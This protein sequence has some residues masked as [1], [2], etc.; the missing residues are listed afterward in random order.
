MADN[1]QEKIEDKIIDCINSESDGRLVIFKPE[2]LNKVLVVERKGEYKNNKQVIL[3]VFGSEKPGGK[4]LEKENFLS[5]NREIPSTGRNVYLV[6]VSFDIVK[7][8]LEDSFLVIPAFKLSEV[9]REKN[10]SKFLMDKRSFTR[11]LL[12]QT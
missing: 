10:L 5:I 2:N 8:D 7:Q 9:K 1:I 3:N 6:F 12:E 11:L 4:D